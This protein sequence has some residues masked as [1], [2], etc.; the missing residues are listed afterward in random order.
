MHQRNEKKMF[1]LSNFA[2]V[3]NMAI[4]FVKFAVGQ[5]MLELFLA[6]SIIGFSYLF[7]S[8]GLALPV[9]SIMA[10]PSTLIL[11]ILTAYVF[12]ELNSLTKPKGEVKVAQRISRILTD[13]RSTEWNEYQDWLHDIMQDRQQ[14]LTMKRPQ[15]QVKLITYRRLSV[16]CVVVGM[17]KVKHAALSI[18]RSR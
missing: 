14:M 12:F 15:W 7:M 3:L 5:L 8:W 18:R 9:A 17:S 2:K 13:K 11:L 4:K 1:R 10:I 16:F 6:V